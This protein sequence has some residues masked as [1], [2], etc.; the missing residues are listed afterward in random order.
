MVRTFN[1]LKP[2]EMIICPKCLTRV[3]S[4]YFIHNEE[5]NKYFCPVVLTDK[6]VDTPCD[7]EIPMRYMQQ[8]QS[9]PPM[10]LQ[11]FGWTAHGKTVFLYTMLLTLLNMSK[12]WESFTEAPLTELDQELDRILRG[13]TS[14]G[15]MPDS[16]QVRTRQQNEVYLRLLDDIPLYGSRTLAM[17]DHAGEMF[18]S[19]RGVPVSEMPFLLHTNTTFMVVSIPRIKSDA[20]GEALDQLLNIYIETMLRQKIDFKKE[21]RKLVVVLTM[22][23]KIDDLPANLRQYL[24][25]DDLWAKQR[26]RYSTPMTSKDMAAYIERMGWASNEIRSWLLRDSEGAPGGANMV[27][28]IEKEGILA[29]YSLVS[30]TGYDIE[31]YRA[32]QSLGADDNALPLSPKRVLDPFLWALD[33]Q[34][35]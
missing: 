20:R 3:E 26:N 4:K 7:F 31:T 6:D 16:T 12:M 17:M 23:D 11:V 25:S 22:A 29:R 28:R 15:Q 14:S 32:E 34:S 2:K 13:S 30:A 24:R 21:N 1:P 19:M 27:R 18:E 8:A 9:A 5:E 35:Q 33:M 10:F